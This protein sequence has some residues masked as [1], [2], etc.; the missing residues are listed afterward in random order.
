VAHA[1]AI[2]VE[3]DERTIVITRVFDAPRD[4]VFKAWTDPKHVAQWWG[5][6]GFT[7]TRCDMDLRAGGVFR[8]HM[9][10]PDGVTYPCKGVYREVRAPERI[11]YDGEAEEGTVGCGAGL[12]PRALV[13]VTFTER[14]GRTTVTIHTVLQSASDREAAVQ[15]GFNSGWASSLDRLAEHLLQA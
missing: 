3:P 13:T 7:T 2:I 9:R 5:P 12:P 6:Q 14:D 1:D 4:L 10:G 15:T 11:V 8:V